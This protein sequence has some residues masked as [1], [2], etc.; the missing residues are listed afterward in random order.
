[1]TESHKLMVYTNIS[2]SDAKE[3]AVAHATKWLMETV[4]ELDVIHEV[5]AD[6]WKGDYN[7]VFSVRLT[8][9]D[10]EAVEE[11]DGIVHLEQIE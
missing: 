8:D 4:E 3:T 11:E 7:I 9:D 2:T 10:L 1:M 6:T 5:C